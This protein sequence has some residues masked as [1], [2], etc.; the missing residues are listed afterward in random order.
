VA[1]CRL[2]ERVLRVT[3]MLHGLRS[4]LSKGAL[5]GSVEPLTGRCSCNR[6]L[7]A[8]GSRQPLGRV[9]SVRLML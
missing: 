8:D 3:L 2:A 1:C 6:P 4:R 7:L 5:L 9:P